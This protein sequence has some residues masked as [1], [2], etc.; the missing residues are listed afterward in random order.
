M[1]HKHAVWCQCAA[2]FTAVLA[3]SS[4]LS[5][6]H[7]TLYVDV[8]WSFVFGTFA[9]LRFIIAE[10]APVFGISQVTWLN[11]HP[12][13]AVNLVLLVWSCSVWQT[14]LAFLQLPFLA[15]AL[16]FTHDDVVLLA[17]CA[18]RTFTAWD[19]SLVIMVLMVMLRRNEPNV[20]QKSLASREQKYR[21]FIQ[22]TEIVLQSAVLWLLRCEH[23]FPHAVRWTPVAVGLM[24]IGVACGWCHLN[25]ARTSVSRNAI[26]MRGGHGMAASLKAAQACPVCCQHIS[27][28]D[29]ESSFSGPSG[30]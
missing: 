15:A 20:V 18:V 21:F 27:S 11:M 25:V 22:A 9:L 6:Q 7:L 30:I 24:C 17:A 4:L 3:A 10:H 12:R 16:R 23:R 28:L 19:G 2:V 26:I 29:M 14:R 8:Y 13:T 1:Y 5:I